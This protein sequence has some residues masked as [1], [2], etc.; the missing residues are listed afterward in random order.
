MVA[1]GTNTGM[2]VN[3]KETLFNPLYLVM[4]AAFNTGKVDTVTTKNLSSYK[5]NEVKGPES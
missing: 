3:L 2:Y 5:N 4:R 1:P